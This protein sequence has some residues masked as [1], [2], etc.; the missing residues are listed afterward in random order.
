MSK[1]KA[2]HSSTN[3]ITR[4]SL[5]DEGLNVEDGERIICHSTRLNE[6]DT[7]VDI[8]KCNIE[9]LGPTSALQT[10]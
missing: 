6:S 7:V 2:M 10:L 1:H 9:A 4:P 3:R 5:R 8:S